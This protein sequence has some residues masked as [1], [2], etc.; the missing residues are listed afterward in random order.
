[1]TPSLVVFDLL[2]TLVKDDGAVQRCFVEVLRSEQL[3]FSAGELES[4]SNLSWLEAIARLLASREGPPL[5]AERVCG[6]HDRFLAALS[7]HYEKP[8]AVREI[9]GAFLTLVALDEAGVAVAVETPLPRRAADAV[10]RGTGWLIHG[11]VDEVV[12]GD[13]VAFA[14][15]APDGVREAMRRTDTF[16]PDRTAK[17]G[18]TPADLAQGTLARCGWVVGATYGAYRHDELHVRPHTH[19]VARLPDILDLFGVDRQPMAR[20]ARRR[21]SNVTT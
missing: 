9:D 17:V 5:A 10:L 7:S 6:I 12:T 16:H 11:V 20:L 13:D 21:A 19:L 8:G 2:D 4:V 14:R 15:P 1:M 3:L 18:T